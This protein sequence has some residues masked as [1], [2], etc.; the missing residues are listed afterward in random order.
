M[1]GALIGVFYTLG[2]NRWENSEYY[3]EGAF[4]LF[5]AA[6]ITVVGA[7]LLRIG[8]MQEKWR[9]RLAE[10]LEAPSQVIGGEGRRR[11]AFGGRF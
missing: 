6:V 9:V 8:K 1:A 7:A 10:A 4:S 11:V 3:Y 2:G 5:A